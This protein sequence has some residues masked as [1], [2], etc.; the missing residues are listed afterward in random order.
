MIR[1]SQ[2]VAEA[3]VE[4]T[5]PKT[6]VITVEDL[7]KMIAGGVF[8]TPCDCRGRITFWSSKLGS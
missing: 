4:G 1:D 3:D 2:P 5:V 6:M 7:D 8:D